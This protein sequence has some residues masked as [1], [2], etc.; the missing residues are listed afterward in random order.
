MHG[1]VFATGSI[2]WAASLSYN[3]YENNVAYITRNVVQR[4]LDPLAL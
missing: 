1:A 2:T 4:F 3:H